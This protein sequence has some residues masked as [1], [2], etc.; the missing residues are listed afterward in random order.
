[1]RVCNLNTRRSSLRQGRMLHSYVVFT[2][3]HDL[4]IA[5]G[6]S[7]FQTV[8]PPS[9][10]PL[11]FLKAFA[12][13]A[14][15]PSGCLWLTPCSSYR[16]GLESKPKGYFVPRFRFALEEGSHFPPGLMRMRSGQFGSCLTRSL[17]RFGASLVLRVETPV[18]RVSPALACSL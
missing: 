17:S 11:A 15:L 16:P 8:V 7:T 5:T 18:R 13:E 4:F 2:L 9:A 10:Y 3:A 1:M 14:I 12:F 6:T